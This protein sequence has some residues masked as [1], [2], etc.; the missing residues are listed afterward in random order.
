M[1]PGNPRERFIA[2]V[3]ARLNN[4]FRRM[5]LATDE[6]E[7][8]QAEQIIRRA[9]AKLAEFNVPELATITIAPV[10]ARAL[11]GGPHNG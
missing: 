5:A 7:R 4:G 2:E 3:T 6:G 8:W 9:R 10:D 11:V 1:R